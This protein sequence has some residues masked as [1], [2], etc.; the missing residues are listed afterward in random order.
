MRMI[1][2]MRVAAGAVAAG[3]LLAGCGSS[4]AAV[5]GDTAP[6]A[7]VDRAALNT[8]DF[9]TTPQP[10][11]GTADPDKT[12]AIESQ[13]MAEFTTLPFE[14][15]PEITES[16]GS[17]KPVTDQGA[18]GQLLRTRGRDR[19]RIARRRVHDLREDAQWRA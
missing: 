14:V 10:P 3:V 11:Y 16:F 13:R 4:E 15:D 6:T 8:G 17:S 9:P 2:F 12:V 19:G 18:Q 1:K 5:G 7:G